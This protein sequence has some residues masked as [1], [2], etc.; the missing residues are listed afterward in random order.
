VRDIRPGYLFPEQFVED[1]LETLRTRKQDENEFFRIVFDSFDKI[2]AGFPIMRMDNFLWKVI[3][4]VCRDYQVS[5][6]IK[7]A[8]L[9]G[10]TTQYQDMAQRVAAMADNLIQFSRDEKTNQC[11]LT[12]IKSEGNTHDPRPLQIVT[13]VRDVTGETK[14]GL[15]VRVRHSEQ[16]TPGASTSP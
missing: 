2:H 10:A 12:I 16:I 8:D 15:Y 11:S 5:A 4:Q 6:I 13:D 7:I 1:L 9:P 3:C 14:Q